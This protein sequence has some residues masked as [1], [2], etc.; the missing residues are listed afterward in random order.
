MVCPIT[1]GDHK[2]WS[3]VEYDIRLF[4]YEIGTPPGRDAESSAYC[5]LS[6]DQ[7][8]SRH[9]QHCGA[10]DLG[11]KQQQPSVTENTGDTVNKVYLLG[12]VSIKRNARNVR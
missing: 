6:D 4:V 11:R 1:Q 12:F 8:H 5:T 9:S 10:V 2:Q 3:S 7:T